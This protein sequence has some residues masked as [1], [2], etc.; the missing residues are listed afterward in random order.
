MVGCGL[1][2]GNLG[3][4][5]TQKARIEFL[6]ESWIETDKRMKEI[7]ALQNSQQF[8]RVEGQFMDSFDFP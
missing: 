1:E 3:S 7:V 5:Y 4:I 2:I 6:T 8:G